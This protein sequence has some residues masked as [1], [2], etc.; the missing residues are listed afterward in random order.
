M[1]IKEVVPL[2][3]IYQHIINLLSSITDKFNNNIT[4]QTYNES[5]PNSVGIILLDSRND[6]WC[7]SGELDYEALKLELRIVCEQSQESIIDNMNI[8][9]SFVDSFERCVSTVNG[10]DIEW[11]E[12]LGAKAKPSYLNG[13]GLPECKCIID[14]NYL[15]N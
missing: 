4:A 13:Y 5:T 14:F 12:H 9:R 7:I 10:L 11:A 15:L 3:L 2:E 8:L 1:H 6:S